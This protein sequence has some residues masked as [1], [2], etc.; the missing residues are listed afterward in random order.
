MLSFAYRWCARNVPSPLVEQSWQSI[1]R[2]T[3]PVQTA[4]LVTLH[5]CSLPSCDL[6][7]PSWRSVHPSGVSD[8]R[9]A[10]APAHMR[11]NLSDSLLYTYEQSRGQSTAVDAAFNAHQ[12][13][14]STPKAYLQSYL[15][16][17]ADPDYINQLARDVCAGS[18]L[19]LSKA[20]TLCES[21]HPDH[22]LQANKLLQLLTD[23]QISDHQHRSP[24]RRHANT[25]PHPTEESF[26]LDAGLSKTPNSA[27]IRSLR[28]AISGPPGA[29]KSSLIEAWGVKLVEEG[30]RVAVLAVDP[31]SVQS[32]MWPIATA[33]PTAPS[34]GA[35][36]CLG[37][38]GC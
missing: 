15:R 20:L 26:R 5:G 10:W 11:C 22:L 38:S 36:M 32:G 25:A 6:C 1:Q 8:A 7:A 29:G 19:A 28:I 17:V 30:H 12:D 27:P 24:V 31:S 21:T 18:R 4:S 35:F 37:C 14:P 13:A 9:P 34:H 33:S 23:I 3:L 16:S 2:S